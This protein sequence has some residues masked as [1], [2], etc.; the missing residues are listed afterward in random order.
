[1]RPQIGIIQVAGL[2]SRVCGLGFR[3][4]GLGFGAWGLGLG[5]WFLGLRVYNL[6]SSCGNTGF[7]GLRGFRVSEF[8][9]FEVLGGRS[10]ETW[11][12]SL[13]TLN[14]EVGSGGVGV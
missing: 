11:A 8:Q 10:P 9:V 6:P 5:V 14:H 2:Q 3:V 4:W 1:M 13:Q 12:L 7:E